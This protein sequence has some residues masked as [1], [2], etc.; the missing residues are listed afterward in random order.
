MNQYPQ[1]PQ[2]PGAYPQAGVPPY[3]GQFQAGYPAQPPRRSRTG[4]WIAIIVVV[5]VLLGGGGAAYYIIHNQ[6][7]PTATL[8]TFC[9]GYQKQDAQEIYNTY[10]TGEKASP[11]HS[12]ANL[13]SDFD[14]LA[15]T[16]VKVSSCTVSNVQQNGSTATGTIT[17]NFTVASVSRSVSENINLLQE[18]NQWKINNGGTPSAS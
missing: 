2:Q 8:Q 3:P 18:N 16:G 4:M 11:G 12:I 7:S 14:L 9:D 17:I 10:T 5:I 15:K 1:Y 13:Q 6:G